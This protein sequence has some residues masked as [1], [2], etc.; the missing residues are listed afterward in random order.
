MPEKKVYVKGAEI[1]YV[2]KDIK[3]V[4]ELNVGQLTVL[5]RRKSRIS[6]VTV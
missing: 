1:K 5:G 3:I 2:K 4:L 6:S